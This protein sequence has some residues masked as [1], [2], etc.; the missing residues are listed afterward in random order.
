MDQ[1]VFIVT[2]ADA[3][4][5]PYLSAMLTSLRYNCAASHPLH[6]TVLSRDLL[7]ESVRWPN[8]GPSDSIRCCAPV[9]PPGSVLPIGEYDH[10]TVETYYRLFLEGV[11]DEAVGRVLYLDSDLVVIGDV[12]RIAQVDLGGRTVAAVLDFYVR[13]WGGVE[14]SPALKS[15]SIH[16]AR[17]YFNAGVLV[18]DL[19]A[20]RDRDVR[21]RAITFLRDHPGQV[22]FWDQDALNHTLA[23]DWLELDPRWNRTRNYWDYLEDGT[24]PFPPEVVEQLAQPY[25]VHFAGRRKPWNYNRHPDRKHFDRYVTMSGFGGHRMNAFKAAWQ[26][27]AA[28]RKR[29]TA[30]GAVR[31]MKRFIKAAGLPWKS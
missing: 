17:R 19:R 28:I 15:Q 8:R 27:G 12:S 23:D 16:G 22:R 3:A 11:F 13:A 2:A 7:V 5:A 29:Y 30:Q 1:D 31:R 10:L 21:G 6:V 4:Y 26:W 24:L 14:A 18:I 20:W 9:I 25:V